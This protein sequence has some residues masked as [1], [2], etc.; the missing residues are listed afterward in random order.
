[1]YLKQV[2]DLSFVGLQYCMWVKYV[3]L[4]VY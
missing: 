3:A 2:T 1:M 4:Y